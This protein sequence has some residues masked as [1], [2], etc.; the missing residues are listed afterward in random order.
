MKKRKVII[1]GLFLFVLCIFYESNVYA[2]EVE[3]LSLEYDC[4]SLTND[5]FLDISD[6]TDGSNVNAN[7]SIQDYTQSY[8]NMLN[9]DT[10][11]YFNFIDNNSTQILKNN[12][13]GNLIYLN[14][15]CKALDNDSII[16]I[17]PQEYFKTVG[18][19]TFF[20][21]NYG[22]YIKTYIDNDIA[23][24]DGELSKVFLATNEILLFY[25]YCFNYLLRCFTWHEC[26]V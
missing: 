1:L 21:L 11:L 15:Q 14:G 22:F 12:Y 2:T 3:N 6:I 24:Y 10:E 9:D 20:G 25:S 16:K 18:E 5:D 23:Y 19:H 4:S 7:Y 8:T 17:I 26:Y 13:G